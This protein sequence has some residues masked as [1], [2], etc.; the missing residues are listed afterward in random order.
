MKKIKENI[1]LSL[2]LIVLSCNYSQKD[3]VLVKYN[4]DGS[5]KT[6][7]IINRNNSKDSTNLIYTDGNLE[8]IYSPFKTNEH[9]I[10]FLIL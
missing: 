9:L 6:I 3:K 8:E 2:F 7:N 5:I 1:L 10:F 4:D